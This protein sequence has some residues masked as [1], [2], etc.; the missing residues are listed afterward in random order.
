[1]LTLRV[2]DP[3]G[4]EEDAVDLDGDFNLAA[5]RYY[6]GVLS[7]LREDDD[8]REVYGREY[9]VRQIDEVAVTLGVDREI[10]E[11][12]PRDVLDEERLLE[13]IAYREEFD[14]K[15]SER[16][17]SVHSDGVF[18]ALDERWSDED[19]VVRPSCEAASN[20]KSGRRGVFFTAHGSSYETRVW[21]LLGRG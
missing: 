9:T 17:A 15:P 4:Y 12:L 19:D 21:G 2:T 6:L 14:S 20:T 10:R 5:R 18:V 11:I 16:V 3:D 8:T 13:V 1:M 7:V